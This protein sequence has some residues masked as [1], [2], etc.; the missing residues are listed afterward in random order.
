MLIEISHEAYYIR[1]TFSD[2]IVDIITETNRYAHKVICKY[3]KDGLAYSLNRWT[4]MIN[5]SITLMILMA[6][7]KYNAIKMAV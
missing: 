3:S 2:H 7:N 4:E 1:T 6:R 5:T